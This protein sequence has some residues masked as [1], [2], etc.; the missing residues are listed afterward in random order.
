MD[1]ITVPRLRAQIATATGQ[2]SVVEMCDQSKT[3]IPAVTWIVWI[4]NEV[5][6]TAILHPG[7]GVV[8]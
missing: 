5:V 8:D 7:F 3:G 4:N 6:E 1:G 2:C